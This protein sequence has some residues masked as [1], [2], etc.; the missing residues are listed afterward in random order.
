VNKAIG[1]IGM[2]CDSPN[3]NSMK[4]AIKVSQPII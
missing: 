1:D 3:R 2:N 4:E